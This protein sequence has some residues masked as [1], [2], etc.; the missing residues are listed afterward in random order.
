MEEAN[1]DVS[2]EQERCHWRIVGM[3]PDAGKVGTDTRVR[4]FCRVLG[5][6][7][8]SG[9]DATSLFFPLTTVPTGPVRHEGLLQWYW[10]LWD[11]VS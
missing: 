4:K 9:R 11:T 6:D 3:V 5:T 10:Q 7:R 1:I 8:L 2:D